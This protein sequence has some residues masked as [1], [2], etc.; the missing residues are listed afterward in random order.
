MVEEG[1]PVPLEEEWRGA[2]SYFLFLFFFS[3]VKFF[4]F[5]RAGHS[6]LFSLLGRCCSVCVC[7]C[8]CVCVFVCVCVCVCACMFDAC[9]SF[10]VHGWLCP[11]V[12]VFMPVCWGLCVG[13][14]LHLCVGMLALCCC[15]WLS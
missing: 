9:V 14:F 8:V 5:L 6:S 15:V 12:I 7:V 4:C 1:G 2:S 11:C 3:S 13:L 10:C